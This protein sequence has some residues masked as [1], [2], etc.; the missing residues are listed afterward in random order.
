MFSV[1][2]KQ[3]NIIEFV[4]FMLVSI[5]LIFNLLPIEKMA[6]EA[7]TLV[8]FLNVFYPA[9]AGI[10]LSISFFILRISGGMF[11]QGIYPLVFG[12]ATHASA[13]ICFTY[14]TVKETYW[15]GD[16]SDILF[17]TSGFLLGYALLKIISG[18]IPEENY[19]IP[20][21]SF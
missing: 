7:I 15:N 10:L 8:N 14:R 12:L 3:K 19:N 17:V 11:K 20:K 9:A 6:E 2:I 18:L 16:I 21:N 5:F 1:T 13:D 4:G